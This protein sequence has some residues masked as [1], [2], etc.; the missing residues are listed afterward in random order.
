MI[1]TF[2]KVTSPREPFEG[3]PIKD[4][5]REENG[6]NSG[7]AGECRPMKK[8]AIILTFFGL[9]LAA[10]IFVYVAK[11]KNRQDE[12]FFS[13]TIEATD[14]QLAFQVRGIVRDVLVSEGQAVK[15]GALLAVLDDSEYQAA[16]GQAAANVEAARKTLSK[17]E[18]TLALLKES[19]PADIDRARAAV[20]SAGAVYEEAKRNLERYEALFEIKA[21]SEQDRDAMKRHRD[22][23]RAGLAESRAALRQAESGLKKIDATEEERQ[24]AMAQIEALEATRRLAEIQL[25]HTRLTAPFEG[26]VT[27]RNVEPGEVVTTGREVLTVSDLSR[28]DLK[29]YVNE[30]DLGNVHPGQAVDVKIDTFPEKTYR[31][32]V[33]YISPEGEFTPKIIQTRKER[34]K[35]VYLV[36][37]SI[38]NE[39]LE[40]KTGMPAD[41]WLR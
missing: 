3:G 17:I 29:I 15:P 34:V 8:K 10:A 22:P 24:A 31:G 14:S 5:L 20:E 28:V 4:R 6:R 2:E 13:G 40:L 1:Q 11:E 23:A 30:T 39:R 16:L 9:F 25:G 12:L 36:K 35:L 18:A 41:A 37:V 26:I 33:S 27:S 32:T 19:L 38:P 21:V 7:P